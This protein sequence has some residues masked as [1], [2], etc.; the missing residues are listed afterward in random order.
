MRNRIVINHW[1]REKQ[2]LEVLPYIVRLELIP[3]SRKW[4]SDILTHRFCNHIGVNSYDLP[5]ILYYLQNKRLI[6][7]KEIEPILEVKAFTYEEREE[8]STPIKVN[9]NWK[10]TGF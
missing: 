3:L 4:Y 7:I 1:I 9:S 8:I 5:S 10:K 2:W 6:T